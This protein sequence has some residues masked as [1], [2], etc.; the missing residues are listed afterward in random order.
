[1][2]VVGQNRKSSMRV[3]VFRFASNNGHDG[4]AEGGLRLLADI[5]KSV[6]WLRGLIGRRRSRNWGR[7]SSQQQK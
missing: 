6:G 4:V 7:F 5:K 3:D 1:M 2:T